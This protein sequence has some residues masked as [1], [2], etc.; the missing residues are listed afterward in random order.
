MTPTADDIFGTD[1]MWNLVCRFEDGNPATPAELRALTD[2]DRAIYT[3]EID[4]II[5]RDL[6][7]IARKD[8]RTH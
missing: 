1:N 2:H 7:M 6:E 5:A 8:A 4:R 3:A